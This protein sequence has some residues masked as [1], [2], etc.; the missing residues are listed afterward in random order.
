MI[1]HDPTSAK[2][3]SERFPVVALC[4]SAGGLKPIEEIF[5]VL[6]SNSGM[7]FI[8]IQHLMP[9][10]PSILADLIQR[11]TDIPVV[12]IADHLVLEP[13]HVYVLLPG[14]EASLWNGELH[15][16]E[17]HKPV[18]WPNTID[19]FLNSLARDQGTQAAA[20]ILSGAGLDGTSGAQVVRANGGLVIAQDL[21]SAS[22]QSMPMH[23]INADFAH[24]VLKPD[25]IPAYLLN[26]FQGKEQVTSE[27]ETLSDSLTDEAL[28]QV[29]ARLRRQMGRD[30]SDYKTS[31]L[32]RQIANRMATLNINTVTRY[33]DYMERHQEEAAQLVQFCSFMSHAF[34]STRN[35]SRH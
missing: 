12:P 23:V 8:I 9:T 29:I 35:R 7:A 5:D 31:T 13:D 10:S 20:V 30:F 33:L 18:G 15:V 28:Q 25:Q 2:E 14:Q 3:S 22:H 17:L 16:G 34:S 6:P 27:I 21:E 4:A 26:H 1:D 19:Q 32:S 11:H 24:A